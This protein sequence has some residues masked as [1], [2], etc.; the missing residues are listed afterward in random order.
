[1]DN[2]SWVTKLIIVINVFV[3][4]SWN[5][6]DN[7]MNVNS[8]MFRHFL[9][10]WDGLMQGRVWTL[11]TSVFSHNSLIHLFFNMY[12]LFNFGPIIETVLGT[13]SFIKFYLMAGLVSSLTHVCVSAFLLEKPGLPALGASGSI[14]GIILIFSLLFPRQILLLFGLIP[15]RALYGALIFVGLD[16]WGLIMQSE[17]GGLPIGHGAHLGG[18][19]FGT[20]YYLKNKSLV[21]RGLDE[22]RK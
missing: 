17:G 1:M 16:L 21:R 18:A 22:A 13:K 10:S 3:F 12:V 9:V 8:W 20:Y 6:L 5:F 11:I 2:K 19:L 14:S 15:I 7:Q 4:L